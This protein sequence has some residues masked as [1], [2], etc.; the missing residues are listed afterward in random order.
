MSIGQNDKNG[1]HIFEVII[2]VLLAVIVCFEM[3]HCIKLHEISNN[4][5]LTNMAIYGADVSSTLRREAAMLR[6]ESERIKYGLSNKHIFLKHSDKMPLLNKEK[7]DDKNK[8]YTL[9][10]EIPAGLT[11]D[12]IWFELDNNILGIGF[13]GVME[14]E[15]N[16]TESADVFSVY[17][18]FTIPETK[19]KVKDIK[20]NINDGI[21]IVNIPIIK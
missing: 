3:I 5:Q 21:L 16:D 6:R 12:D 17:R 15:N 1:E 9:E 14:M 20:Y 8:L 10:M 4:T 2:V 19:A 7:Y 13:G 11:K 18:F